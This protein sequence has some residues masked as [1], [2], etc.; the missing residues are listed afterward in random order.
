MCSSLSQGI[1]DLTKITNIFVPKIINKKID[2][3]F[4]GGQIEGCFVTPTIY[5]TTLDNKNYVNALV[6][7]GPNFFFT[8]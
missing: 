7:P 5:E 1:K 3:I 6:I 8:T 2:K 4:V